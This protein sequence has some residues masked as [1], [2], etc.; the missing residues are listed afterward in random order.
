MV[1]SRPDIV[2]ARRDRLGVHVGRPFSTRVP[3]LFRTDGTPSTVKVRASHRRGAVEA[4]RG[5]APARHGGPK[6]LDEVAVAG[7]ERPVEGVL[8]L[9]PRTRPGRPV[10]AT[11]NYF[12]PRADPLA[13]RDGGRPGGPGKPGDDRG[14]RGRGT[15]RS[16]TRRED[17]RPRARG[18]SPA[19]S[20]MS[21]SRSTPTTTCISR[22]DPTRCAA[23]SWTSWR[24]SAGQRCCRGAPRRRARRRS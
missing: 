5:D 24:P 18:L 13:P 14:D 17:R 23:G 4:P 9:P 6:R 11:R 22:P 3:V 8:F 10:S 20:F 21:S 7:P 15:G 19:A 16:E 1:L 2:S 12:D